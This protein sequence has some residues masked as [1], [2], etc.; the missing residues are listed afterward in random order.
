[1]YKN[2]LIKEIYDTFKNYS[3]EKISKNE[4]QD[5]KMIELKELQEKI[6]KKKTKACNKIKNTNNQI[7]NLTIKSVND[8]KKITEKI[9][10]L[11]INT[12]FLNKYLNLPES[13]IELNIVNSYIYP[14]SYFPI[15][16]I[17]IFI[18]N[19]NIS[20]LPDLPK[21]LQE[22]I[23]FNGHINKIPKLP[24][25][26]KVL[27]IG[28]NNINKLST[29][30]KNLKKLYID[31]TNISELHIPLDSKLTILNINNTHIKTINY[32]PDSLIEFSCKT[33]LIKNLPNIP[34]NIKQLT[35][36][37]KVYIDE[38]QY[39]ILSN[40]IDLHISIENKII[41]NRINILNFLL[42]NKPVVLLNENEMKDRVEDANIELENINKI[43][44]IN[45]N[46]LL[47]NINIDDT[48]VKLN[49]N[50]VSENI[51][52]KYK[53]SC[54][55]TEDLIGDSLNVEYGNIV[56]IDISN[57]N[58]YV[59]WCFT[60]PEALEMWQFSKT[61]N[62]HP[63][64]GQTI[65]Q[66]G[67]LLSRLYN[68]FVIRQTDNKTHN[69]AGHHDIKTIYTL[70]PISRDIFL[71]KTKITDDIIKNFIPSINDLNLYYLNNPYTQNNNTIK[72]VNKNNQKFY[73]GELGS[74]IIDDTSILTQIIK[75]IK[76]N[77][78]GDINKIYTI[79]QDDVN[80]N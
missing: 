29:I 26:L 10:I 6:K 71:N 15:N 32:L 30:N 54:N 55:N 57:S 65:N 41:Y 1:M 34:I 33:S 37:D 61:Y 70:D 31:N 23:C 64:T 13:L 75:I 11:N 39:D 19:S 28:N 18:E 16:L 42:N 27:D 5:L 9:T 49:I 59:V 2:N 7:T 14:I 51:Q 69:Y 80:V 76:D 25:S 47:E 21:N 53:S 56:V 3:N 46:K 22:L 35:L 4:L 43:N 68:T 58:K 48:E 78:V 60:Y 8:L 50:K 12:V 72:I 40:I 20:E 36:N 74:L 77:D 45:A 63:Y 38:L 17:K 73:I 44:K 79:I 52:S 67:I 24:K 66:R 62:I